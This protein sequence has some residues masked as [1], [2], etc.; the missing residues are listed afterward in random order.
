MAEG[1]SVTGYH[2]TGWVNVSASA[3]V[4]D[5]AAPSLHL[6]LWALNDDN[7]FYCAAW[8]DLS[9]TG[10]AIETHDSDRRAAAGRSAVS[11]IGGGNRERG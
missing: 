5:G 10:H 7:E 11:S 9:L 3:P 1:N 8:R 6:Q 4:I 2:G